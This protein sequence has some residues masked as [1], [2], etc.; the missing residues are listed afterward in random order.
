MTDAQ[1]YDVGLAPETLN[2]GSHAM[3]GNKILK[4]NMRLCILFV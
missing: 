1:T 3:Y 2:V 4:N